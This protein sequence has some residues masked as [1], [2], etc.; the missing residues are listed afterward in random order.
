MPGSSANVCQASVRGT[1]LASDCTVSRSGGQLAA[2]RITLWYSSF[3]CEHC[4]RVIRRSSCA[5]SGSDVWRSAARAQ[6]RLGGRQVGVVVVGQA[7]GGALGGQ[8]LE[9]GADEE[10]VAA[11]VR[12]ERLDQRAAVAQ[13][14]DQADRLQLTQRL[15]DRRAADPEPRRQVL[16]AQAG[17]ERDAPGE[18]LDLQLVGEIVRARRAGVAGRAIGLR[19]YRRG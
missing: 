4:S 16:L 15:A 7:A 12:L 6:Q 11:L 18:D 10:D 2:A 19:S 3:A 13:L 5:L 9:L 8:P 14:L 17:A 1:W